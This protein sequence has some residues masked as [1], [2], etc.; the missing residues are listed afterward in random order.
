MA[1][2]NS[3]P[4]SFVVQVLPGGENADLRFLVTSGIEGQRLVADESEFV[5]RVWREDGG[6]QGAETIRASITNVKTGAA[7]MLQG[8]AALGRLAREMAIK[9]THR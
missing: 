9:L 6:P 8:N 5:V 2:K 1:V 3:A 4:L 7:A